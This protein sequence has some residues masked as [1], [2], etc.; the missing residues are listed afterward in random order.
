VLQISLGQSKT[1]FVALVNVHEEL[2]VHKGEVTQ[3]ALRR[4]YI[5]TPPEPEKHPGNGRTPA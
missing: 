1:D 5:I 3:D 4:T 2:R